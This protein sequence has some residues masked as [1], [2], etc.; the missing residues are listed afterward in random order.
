MPY[1]SGS[2]TRDGPGPLVFKASA[3]ETSS[4]THQQF[5]SD[6]FSTLAVVVD[7]TAVSG[8]TPTMTVVIEGSLDNST[9]FELGTIGTAGAYRVGTTAT[10]PGNITATTTTRGA[11]PAPPFIRTRSVIGGT[12]PSFTYSCIGDLS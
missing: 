5:N 12:T 3:A 2:V 1:G 10:A 8:T 6:S 11:F 9:W 4:T 7:V